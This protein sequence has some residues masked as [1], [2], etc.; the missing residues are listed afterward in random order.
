M[1]SVI[2]PSVTALALIT[3]ISVRGERN[4]IEHCPADNPELGLKIQQLQAKA[5]SV[6]YDHDYA[7]AEALAREAFGYGD[8]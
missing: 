6:M 5:R 7:T 8:I 2:G 1:F 4:M 3:L